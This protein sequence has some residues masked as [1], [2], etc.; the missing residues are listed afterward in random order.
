MT[1]GMLRISAENIVFKIIK[2]KFSDLLFVMWDT[3]KVSQNRDVTSKNNIDLTVGWLWSLWWVQ[4]IPS[5][6]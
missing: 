6:K 3:V 2:Q 5:A 1:K 4:A